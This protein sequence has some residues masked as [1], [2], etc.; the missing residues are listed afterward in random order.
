MGSAPGGLVVRRLLEHRRFAQA[1]TCNDER[2]FPDGFPHGP[3]ALAVA[4]ALAAVY[5]IWGSTYLAIRF[6]LEGGFPA[7]VDGGWT[8]PA[9]GCD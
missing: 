3:G 4:L 2:D 8:L 7:A 6:A 9:R 5:L 1:W